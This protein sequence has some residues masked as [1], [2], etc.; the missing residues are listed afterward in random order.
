MQDT[1]KLANLVAVERET[2]TKLITSL[3][4]AITLAKNT[5]L[6]L[7][8]RQDPWYCNQLVLEQLRKQVSEENMLQKSIL[9]MQTQ[10]AQ[11]E[12]AL[13]RSIQTAYTTFQEYNDKMHSQVRKNWA[14][15]ADLFKNITPI[16][17]WEAFSSRDDC[18]LD[19]QTPLRNPQKINYPGVREPSTAAIYQGILQRKKKYT[20]AYK[21]GYFV[22]TPSGFL[23][24]FKSSN[25]T[26]NSVPELSIFLLECTLGAPSAPNSRSHKFTITI[27]KKGSFNRQQAHTL[28]GKSHVE[29]M[30][31]WNMLKD[32]AKVYLTSSTPQDHSGIVPAAV[33]AI[34]YDSDDSAS[35][36][37]VSEGQGQVELS[38]NRQEE[39]DGTGSSIEEES[40]IEM[41]ISP[42]SP[43]QN[44]NS[45]PEF[46]LGKFIPGQ[47]APIYTS[48][49]H[50]TIEPTL[51]E[52]HELSKQGLPDSKLAPDLGDQEHHV[53]HLKSEK[54]DE[55]IIDSKQTATH[56]P[57][58]GSSLGIMLS[59]FTENFVS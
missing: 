32:L 51:I 25:L 38:A 17:E 57:S 58:Q 59:R 55:P 15:S 22:L 34:G 44:S 53:N 24:E 6:S 46:P 50:S 11:F 36:R 54:E 19:P 29:I 20:K 23:H 21:E 37:T 27:D 1:G 45:K 52:K 8:W 47:E 18:L 33:R 43:E 31:W 48:I 56:R 7:D 2:S 3:V 12:E 16:T 49:K 39:D 13:V 42:T 10:S 30:D 28:R 5:P 26:K 14:M 35:M 41:P 40:S 4:R 9:I